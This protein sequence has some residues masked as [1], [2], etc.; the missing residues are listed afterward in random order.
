MM[1]IYPDFF[2]NFTG[3]NKESVK[4]VGHK[5]S[6]WGEK[7]LIRT[8]LLDNLDHLAEQ[9]RAGEVSAPPCVY[10]VGGPGNGKSESAEYFLRKLYGGDLPEHDDKNKGHKIFRRRITNEIE[11]VVVVED[12]TELGPGILKSEVSEFALRARRGSIYE[13]YIYVCCVNRGV[14]ADELMPSNAGN[15]TTEFISAMSDVV[16]VGGTSSRMWPLRGNE[17]FGAFKSQDSINFVYVWPMDAESLLDANLYG[18]DIRQTPGYKLLWSVFSSADSSRCENC[19][20]RESCPFYENLVAV[21]NGCCIEDLIY[22]LHAFEISVGSRLLFR[23]LLS[24]ASVVFVGSED[25]YHVPKGDRKIAATPCQWVLH[26]H[27]IL[28]SKEFG[29]ESLSSAFNLASRRYNQVLFGDYTEFLSKDISRLQSLLRGHR[30]KAVEF[31]AML[32][33]LKTI[34]GIYSKRKNITPA[35]RLIHGDLCKKLDVALEE[36]INSLENIEMAFCSSTKIGRSVAQHE[37]VASHSL[38]KL[39]DQFVTCEEALGGY[40]FD[41]STESGDLG[42]K[43]LQILQVLGSRM[44]KREVGMRKHA[45]YN[46]EDILMYETICYRDGVE[47]EVHNNIRKPLQKV[48]SIDNAFSA[49]VLQAVGQTRVSPKYVFEIKASGNCKIT[50]VKSKTLPLTLIAPVDPTPDIVIKYSYE[51][52]GVKQVRMPLTFALFQALRK[53]R[54]GLSVASISEQTF[55]VLNLLSSR[56]LGIITHNAEEPRFAFPGGRHFVW[57]GDKLS[58]ED[59]S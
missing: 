20:G 5:N 35:W 56:L 38:Q 22:C 21:R 57:L 3:S 17:R 25:Y 8:R 26:N 34:T 39:L 10:L 50:V 28:Q 45:V 48:L 23:D 16:A 47:S 33:L 27:E 24:I 18:G 13:R 43:C 36:S 19:K 6:G 11:G 40:S 53:V 7:E 29:I 54:K 52:G 42:R 9:V 2:F 4:T 31:G 41:I 1:N 14:L 58:T 12:A 49:H 46:N 59:E 44:S 51:D 32:E 15:M 30:D 55:V 37:G